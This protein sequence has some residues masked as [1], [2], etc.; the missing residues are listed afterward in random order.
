MANVI[1]AKAVKII[2]TNHRGET[3]LRNIVP[4]RIFFGSTE[5]HPETQWLMDA[6]DL[7][8]G[9]SRSF[10]MKDVRAWIGPK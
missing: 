9:Q 3:A 2:Y 1:D 7:D 8:K 6:I 10:A 4:E 5:W